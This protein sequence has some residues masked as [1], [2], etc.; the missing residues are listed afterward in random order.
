[1]NRIKKLIKA[2]F[3]SS[4]SKTPAF[5][6][7]AKIFRNEI[8]KELPAGAELAAY[9]V[10]HFYVS[11]FIKLLNGKL[12]YFSISDVRYFPDNDLLIRSAEHLKDYSGGK[13][14]YVKLEDGALNAWFK[15]IAERDSDHTQ[16]GKT[17][18]WPGSIGMA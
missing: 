11:G 6:S 1:M 12:F 9:S 4:T 5:T 2:G 7:F 16:A 3:E 18:T 15:R 10:G 17:V 13:N 8:K 14:N